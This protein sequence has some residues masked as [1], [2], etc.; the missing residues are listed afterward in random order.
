M[1]C[2]DCLTEIRVGMWPLGCHG[3]GDHSLKGSF[4]RNPPNAHAKERTV[5]YRNPLTGAISVPGRADEPMHPK[6]ARDGYERVELNTYREVQ[7]LES[8][9]LVHAGTS[10]NGATTPPTSEPELAAPKSAK[11]LGLI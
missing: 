4:I 8:T 2:E 9:G 3:T 10:F 6:L 11:E 5:I 7:A 1:T